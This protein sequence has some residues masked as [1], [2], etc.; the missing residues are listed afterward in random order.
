M[1]SRLKASG[2]GKPNPDY[3]ILYKD[4]TLNT[5]FEEVVKDNLA[6]LQYNSE[7]L[8]DSLAHLQKSISDS[9]SKILPPVQ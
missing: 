3:S 9:A 1:T 7:D 6:Q 2:K 4:Q 5:K 8:T